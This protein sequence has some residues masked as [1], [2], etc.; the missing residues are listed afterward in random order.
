MMYTSYSLWPQSSMA[1]HIMLYYARP[2]PS[3]SGDLDD[4]LTLRYLSPPPINVL[5]KPA[6]Q[7][8]TTA[9]E[10]RPIGLQ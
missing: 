4:C 2:R 3:A 8:P 7:R 9:T 10:Q 6:K 5:R 1:Q